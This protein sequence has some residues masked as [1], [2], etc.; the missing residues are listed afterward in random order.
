MFIPGALLYGAHRLFSHLFDWDPQN[1]PGGYLFW[2]SFTTLMVIVF[3]IVEL[4]PRLGFFPGAFGGKLILS[5][6]SVDRKLAKLIKKHPF[7]LNVDWFPQWAEAKT[8]SE[9]ER[10]FSDLKEAVR[11]T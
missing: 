10:I 1:L 7:K 8:L 5:K 6:S 2:S 3:L 4:S 11:G 9:Q